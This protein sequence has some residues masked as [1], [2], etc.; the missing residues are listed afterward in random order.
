M[1][2]QVKAELLPLGELGDIVSGSTPKTNVKDFWNGDIP[3]ITPADL[4]NHEGVWFRGK[5]KRIT[6]SGFEAC[7]TRMLPQGSILFSS[8]APIGHCAVAAYPLCTNQGF[9]SLVPNERLDPVHT[10]MTLTST[11]NQMSM[12]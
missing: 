7:S 2:Y 12:S 4:S 8:R 5:L 11:L 3:W 9:K 6:R 1:S 10:A